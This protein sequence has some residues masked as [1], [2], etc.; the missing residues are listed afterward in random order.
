MLG[1]Q[2]SQA[3]RVASLGRRRRGLIAASGSL[4]LLAACG[5][6]SS[7]SGG[8]SGGTIPIA[9]INSLTGPGAIVGVGTL[10]GAQAAVKE[11]NT[12]GGILGKTF[13][14]FTGDDVTDPVDAVA[15]CS[16]LIN[17]DQIVVSVGPNDGQTAACLPYFDRGKVV[18]FTMGGDTHY[19]TIT[20]P[21][22][23]RGVP[24]DN[25]LGFAVGTYA[26][27]IKGYT[28]GALMLAN[29]Q[30]SQ[31]L[32]A[33]ITKAFQHWGGRIVATEPITSGQ[34][35]YLSE[36][37]NVVAAHPQ[38]IF[39]ELGSPADAGVLFNNFKEL[40]NLAIP[41]VGTD[42]TATPDWLKAIGIPVAEQHLTSVTAATVTNA[43]YAEF[44]KVYATLFS[45]QPRDAASN[46]YDA[47]IV[48]ALA[49][50]AAGSTDSSK[51]GPA[52]LQ[53]T[54]SSGTICSTYS[55][56]LA[57][58]KA[59]KQIQYQGAGG[60]V[61]YDSNHQ[62]SAEFQG[63]VATTAGSFMQVAAIPAADV[64]AASQ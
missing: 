32:V 23:F 64:S 44:A 58:L 57:M 24:S 46:A 6:G 7:G 30:T 15:A 9:L 20:D 2:S 33:P 8:S 39:T 45:H 14:L 19:D 63:V 29:D 26:G 42:S 48:S 18:N 5:S 53:V 60:P 37:Q 41:F 47:V 27:K 51:F 3:R 25:L 16:R 40:D 22:L 61:N 31:A 43:S 52:I 50:D 36:A 62:V 21:L 34:S 1:K 59:G 49:M 4:L 28:T 11:V 12:N 56:C 55:S 13:K 10:E 17:L 35:S 54:S 38:V